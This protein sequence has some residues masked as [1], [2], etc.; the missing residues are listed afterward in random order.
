MTIR[1]RGAGVVCALG[2][3]AD[4]VHAAMEDGRHGFRG[5]SADGAA[6]PAP[7]DGGRDLPRDLGRRLGRQLAMTL[8]SVLDSLAGCRAWDED[9]SETGLFASTANGSLDE[10]ADFVAGVAKSGP[11][12][13]SPAL[14]SSSQHN[15]MVGVVARE[16]GI[17]GPA[18]LVTNGEVSF[19]TALV[20]ATTAL[21]TGRMRRAIVVGCDAS[22]EVFTRSLRQFG[23][24]S[25]SPE[26][27]DP[28][29]LRGGRG[30]HLG[31]GAGA[32]VL[33]YDPFGRHGV[34][35]C[36]VR[37][38]SVSP[39]RGAAPKRVEVLAPGDAAGARRHVE[40]LAALDVGDAELRNPSS[41]FGWCY[42]LSAVAIAAEAA[43]RLRSGS[44]GGPTL[45][46]SA[47]PDACA[48]TVLVGGS[49]GA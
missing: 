47:P 24:V 7:F 20:A 35:L 26:P 33:E 34:R 10:T 28:S 23:L 18:T 11:R 32:L 45:F 48:A 37:L 8:A 36:G 14:F 19:E 39:R 22:H 49:G 17:R 9:P 2:V 13:A 1:I 30:R 42:S 5:P 41:R 16:L 44:D 43:R 31:E 29:P 40:A 38:G 4:A 15:A 6:Y 12:Y 27:T 46:V 25:D 21:A 3:G